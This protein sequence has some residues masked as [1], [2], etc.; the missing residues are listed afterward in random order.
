MKGNS[1]TVNNYG[2]WDQRRP[3]FFI[4]SVF[5]TMNIVL[6]KLLYLQEKNTHSVALRKTGFIIKLYK[7]RAGRAI[8]QKMTTELSSTSLELG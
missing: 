6:F 8:S 2:M 7:Q 5:S 1:K 3:E 4:F